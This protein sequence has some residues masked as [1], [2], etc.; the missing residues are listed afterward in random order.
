[1]PAFKNAS[2]TPTPPSPFEGEG[3]FVAMPCN[4]PPPLRGRVRVGGVSRTRE[5][6]YQAD[7]GFARDAGDPLMSP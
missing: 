5:S 1:M 7:L 3:D 2:V 4:S 6:E